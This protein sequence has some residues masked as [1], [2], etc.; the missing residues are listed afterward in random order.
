MA[1]CFGVLVAVLGA[2]VLV[3][4]H[5]H[6]YRLIRVSPS[7]AAMVYNTALGLLLCGG[8]L[9]AASLE[10]SRLAA[11]G[12][13]YA[14]IVGLLTLSEYIFGIHLGID[15]LLMSHYVDGGGAG[16]GR[17]AV[18]TAMCFA[19]IGPA[20]LLLSFGRKRTYPRFAV[21]LIGLVV[22]VQCI[23][24]FSGYLLGSPSVYAWGT[25][26]LMAGHT[27]LGLSLLGSGLMALTW[28]DNKAPERVLVARW[29]PVMIAIGLITA[30]VCLW[31]ALYSGQ[32]QQSAANERH[33]VQ[34]EIISRMRVRA[35]ALERL[36][37]FWGR[38]SK[39]NREGWEVSARLYLRDFP[40]LKAVYWVSPD[41]GEILVVSADKA[42]SKKDALAF[43]PYSMVH[44]DVSASPS[45]ISISRSFDLV[46][47][48]K[49]IHLFASVPGQPSR[50]R[51]DG[52]FSATE[53]LQD[54]FSEENLHP[55]EFLIRDQSIQLFGNDGDAS[56]IK[57][58]WEGTDVEF[59]GALWRVLNRPDDVTL[60]GLE[61]Y[62]LR[63]VLI[64][65][66]IMSF[67]IAL[68]VRLLQTARQS[69]FKVETIHSKLVSE[70]AEREAAQQTLRASEERFKDFFELSVDIIGIADF[71]GYFQT[72]ND[73]FIGVLG[74]SRQEFLSR[75]F[76]DFVHPDDMAKTL[77]AY[78]DQLKQGKTVLF[79]KNRYLH[80]D[81]TAVCLEWTAR[82]DIPSASIFCIA[83][84]VTERER[85][86]EEHRRIE[87]ELTKNEEQLVEAQ[88]IA[89]LG[90]WE[91][92]IPTNVTSWSEALYHIYGV[93][94]EDCP[95]TFEGYLSLVHPD[96]REHASALI[97]KAV[98]TGQGFSYDHRIIWPDKSVRFHHVNL[99]VTLD[100]EGH[101]VKL[102]GTAQDVTDRVQLEEELKEARDVA[103]ESARL[104]SEFLANMSHEIRTPMNGV[105]G[106]TGL[107][108]DTKLDADQREW[109]ETIRSSGDALLTI[110][111]DILDFS[112]I[113]AG[114]LEFEMVDFDLRDAVEETMD[115]LAE[116]ARAKK[117]EFGS[118]VYRDVAT[119]LRGDPGRLR[120]V[121]TNLIGNALKFT[122]QGE[123]I[124]RAEKES[125][126]ETAITIRFTVSDTGI[127]IT[128]A[129]QA[130]LFRA[131]TQ[132]DGS[133][134]RKYGGT[135][136]GL[137]I[138]KQLVE[139]MGGKM[140][141]IS[142]PGEGSTFWFTAEL[143]RQPASANLPLP[144][145][146]SIEN[147]R[148]LIIDDNTTNRKILSH[149][150]K[151]WDMIHAEAE[152]GPRALALLRTAAADGV[153]YDLAILDLLMPVMDGFE[154]ARAIKSD[155]MLARMHLVLLTSAGARGHGATARAAG[156]AAYLTKPVRQSQLFDCLTMVVSNSWDASAETSSKLVTRH[157]LREARHMS[158]R[159]ILLA[160]D[161]IVNQ[162]VAVRQLQKLGYRADAVAN[163][164][165]AIE[166][167][168]RIPYDLV[169]MDC[170]M[171]EM[172]GYEATTE[173]RRIEGVARHT[174]IV[175][176]TAHA[177]TGDRE[178]SI[179][180]G[181][182]DHIT[183]PVKQEEL[184]RV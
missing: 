146:H 104:K 59:Y 29:L 135:G 83:R 142:T 23:F 151:S 53:L 57:K 76:M 172:D 174:P 181:M 48:A 102:F 157:T 149:Q 95:T 138:S 143:A 93:R 144:E 63:A 7:F 1:A 61:L 12:G 62:L 50:G 139:M 28:R 31:Q 175:A 115:L 163:G 178:K 40:D 112:K 8:S 43:L 159:L 79:L 24:A 71:N 148:V 30:T 70:V 170:Q 87:S 82:P 179:T 94:P 165:E 99:K 91:W 131:F 51:V 103:L 98:R 145:I 84:D 2:A 17:M 5:T 45:P 60:A 54:V 16:P 126:S 88:H 118:L 4:W 109:A 80:K 180:A 136:L 105:V 42:W 134:T 41:D 32:Q 121:L 38:Q 47:D 124:V 117:L 171:P 173:I 166:A 3:G 156:I 116:R 141:V 162:K 120:Q 137:S 152:S 33:D 26:T 96:D 77:H 182:D 147:L 72:I 85:A 113:E 37:Q 22:V 183:K 100:K 46:P 161:N 66:V 177:L 153:P 27:A 158:H 110:I 13:F 9:L 125:E 132:A 58:G 56:Q 123:V 101:P 69:T 6:S 49:G 18:N 15:Q 129:A 36:A 111:N 133:M 130:R 176:M 34:A 10:R 107:L 150:L 108:L 167:L 73:S 44:A 155:P 89:L 19:L 35:M 14:T 25:L 168:S 20:L 78:E 75:P 140:G 67:A 39:F 164:R 86:A 122:E 92:D 68:A 21:N 106:T 55:N 154:L 64:F 184:A 128:E 74:Y 114:K 11:V 81:G 97:E 52:L 127:G 160:E 119:G 65:G 90:S 169:L